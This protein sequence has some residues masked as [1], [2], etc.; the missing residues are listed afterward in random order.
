M[1]VAIL[2]R[3][4]VDDEVSPII[5]IRLSTVLSQS[6]SG[7]FTAT[8]N[9]LFSRLVSSSAFSVSVIPQS[10]AVKFTSFSFTERVTDNLS[11]KSLPSSRI[12]SFFL[13]SRPWDP[14]PC[15]QCPS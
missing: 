6:L 7:S 14:N 5:R 13:S 3:P 12:F 9:A 10:A 2:C 4:C 11:D 8:N 15:F 1:K